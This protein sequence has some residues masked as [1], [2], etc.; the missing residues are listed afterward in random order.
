MLTYEQRASESTQDPVLHA[1]E[2]CARDD[3]HCWATLSAARAMGGLTP[4]LVAE[5]I[6]AQSAR[7]TSMTKQLSE[8]VAM[9]PPP[10]IR[11]DGLEGARLA[12]MKAIGVVQGLTP[13]APIGPNEHATRG[14]AM[15]CQ[16]ILAGIRRIEHQMGGQP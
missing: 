8:L 13:R 4:A 6:Q 7:A 5:L 14:Y 11:I 3:P 1:L 10:P 9:T 15:A 2:Q 16:E 12:L